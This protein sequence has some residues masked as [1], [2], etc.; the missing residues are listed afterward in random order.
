MRRKNLGEAGTKEDFDTIETTWV[1]TKKIQ[2]SFKEKGRARLVTRTF[3]DEM[4]EVEQVYALTLPKGIIRQLLSYCAVNAWVPNIIDVSTACLQGGSIECDVYLNP[5]KA[6][7]KPPNTVGK[8]NL[9][10]H[11]LAIAKKAWFKIIQFCFLSIH[12]CLV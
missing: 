12:V 11:G 1:F 3:Q 2:P 9:T 10:V 4:D 5:P 7:M 6:T 8:L